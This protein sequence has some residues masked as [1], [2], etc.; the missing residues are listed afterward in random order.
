[1]SVSI[2]VVMTVH[3]RKATTIE[4]LR[5]LFSQV[6]EEFGIAVFLTDDGS[7]DGTTAAVKRSFPQVTV[8][9]GDGTLFWAGGMRLAFG[10]AMLESFDYYL[11]IND[12]TFLV[13]DAISTLLSTAREV[14]GNGCAEPI[15]IG[16]VSSSSG[17]VATH[18][19]IKKWTRLNSKIVVPSD[20]IQLCET[21][22][23]NC[24]LIPHE[25][26]VAVGNIDEAF[27]HSIG[28][29]DYGLRASKMG[30]KLVVARGFLGV[31]DLNPIVG[32]MNDLSLSL[33]K[34]YRL[35]TDT[36]GLPPRPFFIFLWRH[37]GFYGVA[38]GLWV[39]ARVLLTWLRYRLVGF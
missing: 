39:Y 2:A 26:A 32:S 30:V 28:D 15:V 7:T 14:V 11:W 1:M 35:L 5:R 12:D 27:Q 22:F 18:G 23:G 29:V 21:M 33:R 38:Y 4:C 34:R 6:G 16:T 8:I 20:E 9:P 13:S 37:L 36:K 19:G 25:V 17:A 10:R 24:V 31:C 3:N